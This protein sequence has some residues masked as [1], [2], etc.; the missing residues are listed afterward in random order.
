[1]S[2]AYLQEYLLTPETWALW[3][4]RLVKALFIVLLARLVLVYGGR[5]VERALTRASRG[6]LLAMDDRRSKTL[7]PL[8]RSLLRYVVDVVAGLSL[9]GIF[10]PSET[11]QPILASAGV[12]GL[13]IGFGAQ[14]L[15][16]DIISGFFILYEDQF[17]VGD[18]VRTGDHAGT[19]EDIGL[20]ITR[21]R[22][23]S[24]EL[25]VIPNGKIEAVTN[26]SRGQMRAQVDVG[27]AYEEPLPHVLGVLREVAA[28]VAR[29]YA[30]VIL[31]GPEV[32]GIVDFGPSQMTI[33]VL[34]QTRPM[35]QWA[36][37]RALR[38]KVLEAFSREG[39]EI[40]YPRQVFL[41]GPQHR[42]GEPTGTQR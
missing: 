4:G 12:V 31:E 29:E 14:N 17:A 35:E 15:V 32:L 39:V 21:L 6:T 26:L 22:D 2:A 30:A 28:D 5:L 19:V 36:V 38:H 13:A 42:G 11:L 33:R 18:Y 8:L 24:G 37:E 34:A 3:G 9:L 7:A 40:P 27:V 20:R 23:F 25:H 16:R 1:M 41:Q 10:L